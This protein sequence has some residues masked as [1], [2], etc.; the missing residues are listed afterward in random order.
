MPVCY[1][2]CHPAKINNNYNNN[3]NNNNNNTDAQNGLENL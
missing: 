3:Y 2:H 1:V